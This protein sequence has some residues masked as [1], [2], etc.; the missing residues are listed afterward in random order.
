[1]APAS[2][3][4]VDGQRPPGCGRAKY[5]RVHRRAVQAD[6]PGAW[7]E[8]RARLMTPEA[9]A[10]WSRTERRAATKAMH[11]PAPSGVEAMLAELGARRAP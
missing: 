2:F 8:G 4:Q 6:D 5:L 11:P 9:W 1:M 3:S 10:R 7:S